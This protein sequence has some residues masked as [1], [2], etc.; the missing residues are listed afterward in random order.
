MNYYGHVVP[1]A[2][3]TYRRKH[4][5][6][7]AGQVRADSNC[8]GKTPTSQTPTLKRL[9]LYAVRSTVICEAVLRGTWVTVTVYV[10][11]VF[12]VVFLVIEAHGGT[13]FRTP[14]PI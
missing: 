9:M 14:C 2:I 8:W 10:T 13:W 1:P 11:V 4:I 5:E 7:V 6:P 12:T 3:Q